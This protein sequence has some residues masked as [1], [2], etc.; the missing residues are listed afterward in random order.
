MTQQSLFGKLLPAPEGFDY[1]EEFITPEEE[2]S[3]IAH[4]LELPMQPYKF[5]E[6]E[7]KRLVYNFG[8]SDEP[9]PSWLKE[10]SLRA[11]KEF[12]LPKH[13]LSSAHLIHYP[14]GVPIGWHRDTPPHDI[15]VGISLNSSAR[16]RLR[17]RREDKKWERFEATLEPRSIYTMAGP[18]RYE[19]EH[20]I[21]PVE[22]TRYS[23]TFRT[24]TA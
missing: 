11:E 20:S 13:S 14:A 1:R 21:P 3:L 5:R 16:F 2:R 18:A 17:K 4:V 19:W 10:I 24:T 15:V 7:A 9:F 22:E 6:F 23:L 8:D 12:R